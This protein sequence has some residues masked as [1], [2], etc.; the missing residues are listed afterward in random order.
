[1]V[2]AG[3]ATKGVAVLVRWWRGTT[4]GYCGV[5]W[6]CFYWVVRDN[7]GK[8]L[9]ELLVLLSDAMDESVHGGVSGEDH[10]EGT[11]Y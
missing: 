6:V 8:A 10:E 9:L 4:S 5:C 7:A 2:Y 3:S 1:M 11:F